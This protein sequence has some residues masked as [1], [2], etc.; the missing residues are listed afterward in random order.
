M[1]EP[2]LQF[3]NTISA[4]SLLAGP[5]LLLAVLLLISPIL[6]CGDAYRIPPFENISTTRLPDGSYELSYDLYPRMLDFPSMQDTLK[7]VL[8]RVSELGGGVFLN[9][10]SWD[11]LSGDIG[12]EIPIGKDKRVIWNAPAES[13]CKPEIDYGLRLMAV[14]PRYW[15]PQESIMDRSY[16][17]LRSPAVTPDR[18]QKLPEPVFTAARDDK[19]V[20]IPGGTFSWQGFSYPVAG[21]YLSAFEV[22]QGEYE[23]VMGRNPA[24]QYGVGPNHPVYYVSWL[25]AVVYCNL[26]SLRE[27]LEPCYSLADH[28]FDPRA[29]P[30]W[31]DYLQDAAQANI[32]CDFAASGY[33]LPKEEE[34]LHA[35]S[36]SDATYH[37]YRDA[38]LAA[39]DSLGRDTICTQ[40]VGSYAPNDAGIHDLHSNVAEWTWNAF[41]CLNDQFL[42]LSTD[43]DGFY[44]LHLRNHAVAFRL[45]QGAYWHMTAHEDFK[46]YQHELLLGA[47]HV[48]DA[49]GFRVCRSS[50]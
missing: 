22:T 28:G 32:S 13:W 46:P 34:W 48:Y 1:S 49:V 16:A 20:Y 23:A 11:C 44:N 12:D 43:R 2:E 5:G 41:S 50:K 40:P 3:K 14:E 26:R 33:R 8:L 31:W 24:I 4:G 45:G 38:M 7:T 25:D 17:I 42:G 18:L 6:L 19:L 21:F 29:W 39:R 37:A 30:V 9:I 27:G 15:N 10:P 35:A 47:G 36:G